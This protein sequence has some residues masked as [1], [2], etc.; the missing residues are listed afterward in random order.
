MRL[1]VLFPLPASD[2]QRVP[3]HAPYLV[4]DALPIWLH[5]AGTGVKVSI[6]NVVNAQFL[7][8]VI[9]VRYPPAAIGSWPKSILV[10]TPAVEGKQEL[11]IE[12]TILRHCPKYSASHETELD[13]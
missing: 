3:T 8:Q 6:P 10:G 9:D 12:N 2:C 13:V 11:L 7:S 1:N 4:H 5:G